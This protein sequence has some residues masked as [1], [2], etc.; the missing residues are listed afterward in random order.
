MPR[1]RAPSGNR[2]V[3]AVPARDRW[4]EHVAANRVR[5]HARLREERTAA[6]SEVFS[7]LQ[8]CPPPTADCPLILTGHQP[9][10]F[11][12]GVWVK[13][14]AAAGL[15][16][17]VGGVTLNLTVDND[18]L[19]SAALRLP[20]W[21]DCDPASV[22]LQ[23]VPFDRFDAEVPY[24][25]RGIEDPELFRTFSQRAEPLWR[26]WGFEPLLPRVWAEVANHPAPTLGERFTAARRCWEGKWG[27]RNL[28]L[29]VSRLAK[30]QAF[31]RFA[32]DIFAN[33][34]RFRDVYD[35]SVAE[36][37]KSH[38]IR[39]RSHP[40]PD[41]APGEAPFWGA[42]D[43]TGRR[44]RATSPRDVRP[45]ALTL[46]LFARLFLGDFFLHGIGGG[47]YDEVTDAI[48]RG[49]YGVDPP[50][51]AVTSATLHLPVPP[52]PHTAA[53]VRALARLDRDRHWNPQVF[54]TGGDEWKR[55]KAELI[56]AKPAGRVDRRRWYAAIREANERL[57][58]LV[59]PA[60]SL[61]PAARREA[62]A[63]AVL[64]RRDFSWV[65]YP[66]DVLRPFLQSFLGC[67]P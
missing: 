62:A 24:E 59:P 58:G 64:L 7:L 65:L 10:L 30:T 21:H 19:K 48:I 25:N 4:P 50:A 27:V 63:N 16:A 42:P 32:A 52:F 17:Q 1:Y 54:A 13:N 35:S 34:D 45:R 5:L 3:L 14:F 66:E 56:A 37:R 47:K 22:H 12:P 6:R 36:Y 11:H 26:N 43:A 60:D 49:Y 23:A 20:V 46:T 41:L 31:R 2:E 40:V 51:F 29:P 61:L 67:R 28:E 33:L 9:E 44:T 39:S 55:A 8:D 18:T 15:A 38:G 53:D 57:R